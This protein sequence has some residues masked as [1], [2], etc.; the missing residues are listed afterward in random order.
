M[1]SWRR[2]LTCKAS[3]NRQSITAHDKY[4]AHL[5]SETEDAALNVVENPPVYNSD[6]Q[7]VDA[8]VVM[9][10]NFDAIL[11]KHKDVLI[12][13]EDSGKIG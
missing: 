9:R 4:S 6:S 11:S 1:K 8:R 3:S 5:T 2:N 7:N 10:E 13:G 12:F